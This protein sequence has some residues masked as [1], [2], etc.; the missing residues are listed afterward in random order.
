MVKQTV[1]K[2]SPK[3]QQILADAQGILRT[4]GDFGFSRFSREFE[5]FCQKSRAIT[6]LENT[7]F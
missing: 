5:R 6:N 2:M 7:L 1:S 3:L 4:E